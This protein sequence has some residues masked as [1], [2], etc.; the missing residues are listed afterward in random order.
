[1]IYAFYS[2]NVLQ[3]VYVPLGKL[4]FTAKLYTYKYYEFVNR[5]SSVGIATRYRLDGPG[6]ECRWGE[7]PAPVQN[8]P[9]AHSASY[10]MGIGSLPG[11][12]VAGVWR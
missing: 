10:T 7:F 12:E 5:D 4:N 1:M 11:G 8:G 2:C 3:T 6:M 9:E